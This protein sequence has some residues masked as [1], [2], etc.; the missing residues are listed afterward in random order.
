MAESRGMNIV[1]SADTSIL[2]RVMALDASG[3]KITSGTM[4]MRLWRV[5]PTSGA[6]ETYDFNDDTFKA[7]A[8]T[9]P[10]ASLTHRQAENSTYNTGFWTRRHTVLTGFTVGD[11]YVVE[12]SHTSLPN[13]ITVEFQYGDFEGDEGILARALMKNTV[14]ETAQGGTTGGSNNTGT[15]QLQAGQSAT[16]D[17]YNGDI[18]VIIGG[19]GIGQSRFISDYD[20]ATVT[21]TVRPDWVV[22]PNGTSQY[23]ILSSYGMGLV[24]SVWD[25]DIVASHGIA[26]SAG[27]LLRALNLTTRA[28][29]ATL[30]D[31]LGVA[32]VAGRDLAGQVWEELTADHN[33][34]GTMGAA[35]GSAG[36]SSPAAIADAVWDEDIVAAHGTADTAGLLLRALGAV[37]S[38]RA[39][40]PTLNALLAVPDSAGVNLPDAIWDENIVSAHGTAQTGGLL[41]RIL[42]ANIAARL[43]NA[44]LNALLGV[45]DAA[46]TNLSDA[47]WDEVLLGGHV[48]ADSGAER[49]K[50]VDDLTQTGGAGDLAEVR[51][52]TAKIDSAAADSP[53][54][55]GSLADKL[56]TIAGV[57]GTDRSI[58]F[59]ISFQGSALRIACAVEQF[60]IIQTTPFT[61]AQAQIYDEAGGIVETIGIAD[62]GA[63]DV[64]GWFGYT[65]PSHGLVTRKI[66]HLLVQI[67]DGAATIVS[68]TK[69]FKTI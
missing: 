67:D 20:G 3:N 48:V 54:T 22:T 60:G 13:E 19:T 10:T 51:T 6:L 17:L 2:F 65:L 4:N 5:I 31:L 42:G 57:V 44:D 30:N 38:Q 49:L 50:A 8:I 66:Y 53:A 58:N 39:N 64:R 32:D 33:T 55:V 63:R 24:D 25:E 56:D 1:R 62:F 14:V 34:A 23:V 18:V 69:I 11:K 40:N 35:L 37:I 68:D 45:P 27:A 43:N 61:Q 15:I 47:V 26:S 41:L 59:Q 28:N 9:T 12:Y 29:N 21:A 52:D 7:G 36:G 16:N 46:S